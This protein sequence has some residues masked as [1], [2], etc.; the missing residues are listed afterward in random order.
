MKLQVAFRD[1]QTIKQKRDLIICISREGSGI[2]TGSPYC[3]LYFDDCV[4]F[5]IISFQKSIALCLQK[6]DYDSYCGYSNVRWKEIPL[7]RA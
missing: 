6:P 3:D 5:K 1:K 2:L 7:S 4:I